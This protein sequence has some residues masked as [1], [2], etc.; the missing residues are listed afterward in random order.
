M[1]RRVVPGRYGRNRP[2]GTYPLNWSE[3]AYLVKCVAGWRCERCRHRHETP[4][5]RK[6]CDRFCRHV[7]D[8][9]QRM[10]TVAHLDNDRSNCARWNLAALCQVCHLKLQ[11]RLVMGQV[12]MF[13]HSVWMAWRVKAMEASRGADAAAAVPG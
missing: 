12:F 3:V 8:G 11:T 13:E 10:L 6:G 2:V 1:R 7:R 9:K 5:R 4:S